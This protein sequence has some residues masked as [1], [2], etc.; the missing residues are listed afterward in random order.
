MEGETDEKTIH[1]IRDEIRANGFK[2]KK[3]HFE[4]LFHGVNSLH[5]LIIYYYPHPALSAPG[6]HCS[7]HWTGLQDEAI[8][9]KFN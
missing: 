3:T 2:K 5:V 9:L 4:S 6:Q 7:T 8:E 1:Y